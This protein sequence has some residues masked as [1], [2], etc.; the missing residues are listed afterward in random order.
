MALNGSPKREYRKYSIHSQS[1]YSQP[2]YTCAR[3]TVTTHL[4]NDR[5]NITA[6][7]ETAVYVCLTIAYIGNV[8]RPATD[9]HHNMQ[10]MKFDDRRETPQEIATRSPKQLAFLPSSVFA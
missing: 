10:T 2:S 8:P 5:T 1:F 9:D 7:T 6:K 4:W 3:T